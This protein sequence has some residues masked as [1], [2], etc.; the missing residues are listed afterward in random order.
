[1]KTHTGQTTLKKTAAKTKAQKS[2]G[3]RNQDKTAASHRNNNAPETKAK[4]QLR[5]APAETKQKKNTAE[6]M[7]NMCKPQPRPYHRTHHS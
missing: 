5:K 2:R 6:T 1:M 4:K 3:N 7:E